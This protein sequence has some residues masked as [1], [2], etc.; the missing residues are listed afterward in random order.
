MHTEFAADMAPNTRKAYRSDVS[1][2]LEWASDD[3]S[4]A[5]EYL[6]QLPVKTRTKARKAAAIRSY[7]RHLR[8]EGVLPDGE[9][10]EPRT[11]RPPRHLPMFL[12]REKLSRML[13]STTP[14]DRA[15]VLTLYATG[16][17]VSE[18][19]ALRWC[20]IDGRTVRVVGKGRKERVV[21]LSEQAA[22]ALRELPQTGEYVFP[23]RDGGP[24]SRITAWVIIARLAKRAGVKASPHT[25]RHSFA[26]HLLEGGA[27]LR[28]I[29]ELLG[30]AS[31]ATTQIYTRVEISHLKDVHA[32][33]HPRSHK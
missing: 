10:L 29:Q 21:L 20:D 4:R 1:L 33:C 15:L 16:G 14:R 6:D 22:A 3:L 8:D 19:C 24:L 28:Q 27:N 11:Q 18:V 13:E 9:V 23:G 7:L 5:Q 17:R 26:T 25:L 30:H 12:K 32:R 2:F 31:I